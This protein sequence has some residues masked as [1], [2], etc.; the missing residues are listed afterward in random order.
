LPYKNG[1]LRLIEPNL[2]YADESLTW[3]SDTS[4]IQYM[5]ATFEQ[6]NKGKEVERINEI[7]NNSD[8]YNWMIELDGKAIGNVSINNIKEISSKFGSKAGNYT[9]LIGNKNYWGKGISY[10]VGQTVLEWAF[11]KGQF[12][13]IAARALND[14]VASLAMLRK[15]GFEYTENTPFESKINGKNTEWQNFKITKLSFLKLKTK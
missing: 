1:T 10:H 2:T 12:E 13:I 14:N 5:G 3:T 9:I 8:E 11:S 6:P 4:V 7:L 15:L